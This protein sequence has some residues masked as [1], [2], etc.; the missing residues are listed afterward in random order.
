[1]DAGRARTLIAGFGSELRGDDGFGLHVIRRL[2]DL[3]VEAADVH[4][5]EVGTAGL[6]LAQQLLD[7][8]DRLIVVDAIR[9]GG[10]AGTVYALAVDAVEPAADVDM[11][12]AVPSRALG[13]AN[14]L[15]GLPRDVWIVGCEPAEVDELTTELTP[16][17]ERAV[18]E[19]VLRIRAL[20]G[21]GNSVDRSALDL[22]R[23]DE[24]LQV[25]FWL[26]GEGLG[27]DVAAA[28]IARF[29]GDERAVDAV[30]GHLVAGRYAARHGAGR[31]AR[32]RLTPLGEIEGRR[33]F[34]DEFEPFLARS[35]HGGECGTPDCDCHTGGE[36]RSV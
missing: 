10:P 17:V 16:A 35:A 19:V 28:D 23:R 26:T 7:P 18:D 30:L 9:R 32:Y 1:M 2:R 33:R 15:G 6:T 27:P 4:L 8:Y 25:M 24:V 14:A 12:T 22:E 13:V 21:D 36:C 3:E 34:L 29:V 5:M 31:E 11:H 20:L